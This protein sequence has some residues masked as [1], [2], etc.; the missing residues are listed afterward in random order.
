MILAYLLTRLTDPAPITSVTPAPSSPLTPTIPGLNAPAP[1][2]VPQW[3]VIVGYILAGLGTLGFGGVIMRLVDGALGRRK[4]RVDTDEVYTRVAVTLVEPLRD[5]LEQ[6]EERLAKAET[7][8]AEDRTAW[9]GEVSDL[10][11]KVRNALTEADQAATEA[12]RLRLLVQRWHRSIM[13]P[14]AT[15]EWLRQLVGPDEPAI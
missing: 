4:N 5:R 2:G 11:N 6:T 14:T 1:A 8:H 13:D 10:R 15:I 9:E 12:H 3:L 7:R